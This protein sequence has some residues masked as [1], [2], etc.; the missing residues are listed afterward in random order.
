MYRLA[1]VSSIG[2]LVGARF[3]PGGRAGRRVILLACTLFAATASAGPRESAA[4][5][6]DRKADATEASRADDWRQG[7]EAWLARLEGNFTVRLGI[8]EKTICSALGNGGAGSTQRCTTRKAV[9]YVSAG[10]CRRDGAGS[11]LLCTF[12]AL[13]YEAA[14]SS[15]AGGGA[16]A[17]LL[18]N[19]LP[20]QLLFGIDPVARRIRATI[21]DSNAEFS[22]TGKLAGNELTFK[23]RCAVDTTRVVGSCSWGLWIKAT[24]DGHRILM[25]RTTHRSTGGVEMN[26]LSGIE[27]PHT[28]ELTRVEQPV[29]ARE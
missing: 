3:A 15:V 4:R 18:S 21:G 22:A 1:G 25:T 27:E 23:E 14:G 24:P 12:D 16:K 5:S 2:G 8:E 13:R 11:D 26:T 19:P 9:S 28:F 6:A 7:L 29:P 10:S 17:F 20:R